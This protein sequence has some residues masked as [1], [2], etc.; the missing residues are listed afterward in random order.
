MNTIVSTTWLAEHL[1]DAGIVIADTR[2]IHGDLDGGANL[3]RK[4]H[5]PGAV[6]LDLDIVLSDRSDLTRGRHPLPDPNEFAW[7]LSERGI[8]ADSFIVAYDDAG[9]S[10]SARLWWMMRWIGLNNAVVLDGG[11]PKWIAEGRLLETG[12]GP[13][14]PT[15]S[16]PLQPRMNSA[17]LAEMNDLEARRNG[18]LLI[19][20]RAGERYRGEVEPID[21]RA[22]HIPGAINVPFSENLTNTDV[23]VFRGANELRALYGRAGIDNYNEVI[24]YCGSGVT[25]CHD[26]LA[27]CIAG[28]ETAK[29]YTGSWSEW[30]CHHK[31]EVSA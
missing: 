23:P 19:D 31:V 6:F 18:R 24:C 9:G 28:Y 5:I 8:N 26:L 1:T 16:S 25:A 10:V 30:I 22:G 15:P 29:L 2:W 20:A 11:I 3:Y 12:N 17:L 27:L 14:T 21:A 4:G 13:D 7:K